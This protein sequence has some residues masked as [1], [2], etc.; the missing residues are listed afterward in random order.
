MTCGVTDEAAIKKQ[1]LRNSS[2]LGKHFFLWRSHLHLPGTCLNKIICSTDF[3]HVFLN[4]MLAP[5]GI[6]LLKHCSCSSELDYT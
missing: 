1:G 5:L 4:W 3:S 6:R 2:I